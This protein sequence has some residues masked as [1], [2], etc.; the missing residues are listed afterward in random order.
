M[1]T[2]A[3][4]DGRRSGRTAD[5]RVS[6]IERV[7]ERLAQLL[8]RVAHRLS[9]PAL[10][11][12]RIAINQEIADRYKLGRIFSWLGLSLLGL[13]AAAFVVNDGWFMYTTARK[14]FDVPISIRPW[15]F[16]DPNNAFALG[17][18]VLFTAAVLGAVT[19][20]GRTMAWFLDSSGQRR[21]RSADS[22]PDAVTD[23]ITPRSDLARH[24]PTWPYLIGAGLLLAAFSVGL[25]ELSES[26][27][28]GGLFVTSNK[29]SVIYGWI[30]TFGP[31]VLW[32]LTTAGEQM[33]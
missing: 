31:T 28:A 3:R 32:M 8:V 14:L 2:S 25:H 27:F 21:H 12:A 6:R 20:G 16:S 1:A 33:T 10:Q 29:T 13:L 15:N 7:G 17:I 19:V 26:R 4:R 5:R 11:A 24:I 30:V 9:D 18:A 22:R 23:T